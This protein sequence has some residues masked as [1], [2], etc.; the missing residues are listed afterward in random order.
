MSSLI[1][2][3]KNSQSG[4]GYRH[5]EKITICKTSAKGSRVKWKRMFSRAQQIWA[6]ILTVT[7]CVT[8]GTLQKLLMPQIAYL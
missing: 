7:R 4:K 3:W 8:S 6:Q 1:S 2:A 5:V